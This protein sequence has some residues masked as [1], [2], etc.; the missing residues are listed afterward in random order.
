MAKLTELLRTRRKFDIVARR[1]I[2]SVSRSLTPF[3]EV[4]YMMNDKDDDGDV[5]DDSQNQVDQV[6]LQVFDSIS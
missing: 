4:V 2:K 3:P 5:D 6:C 1:W